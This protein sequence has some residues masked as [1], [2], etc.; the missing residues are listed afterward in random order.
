MAEDIVE[1]LTPQ[2]VAD[3]ADRVAL[4]IQVSTAKR[5]PRSIAEFRSDLESWSCEVQEIAKECT[6]SLPKGNGIIG[7]SVRF[8][9]L[10][11]QAYK[12]LIVDV[13]GIS[14]DGGF[15]AVT[16][17]CR[18]LERNTASRVT[19]R[20]SIKGKNGK[21]Y[22]QH[23]VET[24]IA[25]ASAIARRNAIFQLIPKALWVG[26]WE[27]SK[28]VML[29]DR[30]SHKDMVSGAV[31]AIEELEGAGLEDVEAWVGHRHEDWTMDHLVRLRLRLDAI[32]SKHVE[33]SAAFPA[34]VDPGEFVGEPRDKR[35]SAAAASQSL[36][37][38]AELEPEIDKETGEVIPDSVGA[39]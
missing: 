36:K 21:R 15:V 28:L 5:Y 33:V 13:G 4:D 25:A 20:R 32:Q 18:D 8:A 31:A 29:G 22:Q 39:K 24:T 9:E 37:Q 3:N 14:E 12:N 10:A 1:I 38:A 11:Q 35:P 19:V 30:K 27:R 17:T 26:I 23:M 2:V 7:P 34:P 16:A 6:Y